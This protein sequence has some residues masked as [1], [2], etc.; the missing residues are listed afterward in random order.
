M[1]KIKQKVSITEGEDSQIRRQWDAERQRWYFSITDVMS[2]LTES[3]DARNYWKALKNRLKKTNYQLVT[4][5]NQLKMKASDGKSYMVDTA[6]ADTILKIIQI[7]A[8]Y[9]SISFKAWFDHIDVQNLAKTTLQTRGSNSPIS[10]GKELQD[11]GTS[12]ISTAL[13][14]S[15]D[16][17]ENK[18]EIIVQL[19]LAG[20]DPNK[21]IITV[22]M[23]TLVIKGDRTRPEDIAEENY[24]YKELMWGEFYKQIELSSLVDI[25][26]VEVIESRGLI[27]IRLP[28]IDQT[29]NRFLKIKSL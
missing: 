27:T 21:I 2:V 6:D 22:N 19:M 14:P 20:V 28:K 24:F 29:R 25:D 10:S 18:N 9:N 3:I 26:N 16:I 15:T 17:Y 13:E 23:N 8:P 11:L 7:I 4:D 12:E 5:F 1:A